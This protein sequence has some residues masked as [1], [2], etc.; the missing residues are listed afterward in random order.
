MKKLILALFLAVWVVFLTGCQS[1]PG[2]PDVLER[3]LSALRAAKF[4]GTFILK[5]DG[6][7]GVG[8]DQTVWVGAA[9]STIMANGKVDFSGPQDDLLKIPVK[10]AP[11]PDGP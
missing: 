11:E 7:V 5:S 4:E 2:A 8:S 3:S 9:G 10:P 6:R 1:T